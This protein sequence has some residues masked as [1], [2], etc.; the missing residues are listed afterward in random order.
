[1][2]RREK[3]DQERARPWNLMFDGRGHFKTLLISWKRRA[4]Y[5]DIQKLSNFKANIFG[6]FLLIDSLWLKH[7]FKW[8]IIWWI[9]C[10]LSSLLNSYTLLRHTKRPLFNTLKIVSY[11][12]CILFKRMEWSWPILDYFEKEKSS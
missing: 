10:W 3:L 7:V 9:I 6:I 4:L 2:T 5:K 8:W 12:I 11:K 1:M